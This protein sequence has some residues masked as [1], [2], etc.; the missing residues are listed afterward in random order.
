MRVVTKEEPKTNKVKW[1]HFSSNIP[2]AAGS[3]KPKQ[4]ID[5]GLEK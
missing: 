2:L 5:I 3:A 4:A 1:G